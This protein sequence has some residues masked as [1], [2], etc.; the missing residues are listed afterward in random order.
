MNILNNIKQF[1]SK[2]AVTEKRHNSTPSNIIEYQAKMLS[3]QSLKDWKMAVM[4]A[5]NPENPNKDKLQT[6]YENM[7]QDNH[8]G[9]VIETRITKT[10]QMPFALFNQ[11][12]ERI[13]DAKQLLE[14]VWFQEFIKLVIGAKFQGTTLVELFELD[15]NGELKEINEIPQRNFNPIKGLILKNAG[16]EKGISYREGKLANYYIQIGKDYNDLGLFTLTAPI[17]IAKKLGLGSWL[18]F[19]DKYGIPP[20][21]I[22]TDREDDN[23]LM[24][25]FEMATNFKRNNFMVARGNEKFEIPNLSNSNSAETFDALIKRADNE[26]SKR[27]LGGT[28]LTDEKGFVGSVEVQY[29]LAN[30]R[31][32]SDR[33]LVKNVINKQLIP[34]LVKLSPVYKPLENLYFDWD[35]EEGLTADKLC[36]YISKLGGQ[37]EFDPEQVEEITGLK[38]IGIKSGTIQVE[39]TTSKKKNTKNA[40]WQLKLVD[41]A[42]IN[43]YHQNDCNCKACTSDIAHFN[44]MDLSDWVKV[45]EQI[46]KDKYEGKISDDISED[47]ILKTYNELNKGFKKGYSSVTTKVNE[48]T[49]KVTPESLKMQQNIFKFSGAKN[50]TMLQD[51]NAILT[52]EKGKSWNT[53]KNEVL[54]LNKKYNENYLQAEWQTAKQAGY[55]GANWEDYQKRKHIYPNLKYKTQKDGKVRNEHLSL[56]GVIAPIDSDFWAV[57]YPPNG[58][59]C[60]CYVVQTAEQPTLAKD[61]PTLTEKQLKKEFRG[62]V[63]ISGEVFKETNENKGKPHP[64]FALFKGAENDTKKAFEYSKLSATK[65][66]AYKADN[67][68]IVKVSPFADISDFEE[69]FIDAKLIADKLNYNVDI[70]AHLDSRI[71]V[72]HKNPEYLINEKVSDRKEIKGTSTKNVFKSAEKQGCEIIVLNLKVNQIDKTKVLEDLKSRFKFDSSFPTIK[73]VIIIDKNGNVEHYNRTDFKRKKTE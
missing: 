7:L 13:D 53:F 62:N 46:A 65:E 41:R 14:G 26:I 25:I 63:G 39:N 1:F 57:H 15:E 47:Y 32:E 67:G 31:F 28:G 73:E 52:S 45:M 71:L 40:E 42:L 66:K 3:V 70:E 72:K 2:K 56:Q 30:A 33:I 17:I 29:E 61:I 34:L 60:R 12:N 9:S 22:T 58:W 19:I 38:V 37:F 48:A 49:N 69:N 6:L 21:F 18:D 54:N 8:L 43:L 35:D 51:I 64:Y 11:N 24:E 10:Q 4:L 59:R 68:A 50:Y 20:L 16:D 5:T 55:H 27:F 36:E 23:R 44:A